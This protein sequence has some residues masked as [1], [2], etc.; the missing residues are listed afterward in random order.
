MGMKQ[1]GTQI[2]PEDADPEIDRIFAKECQKAR[3]QG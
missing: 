3:S 1:G 2:E